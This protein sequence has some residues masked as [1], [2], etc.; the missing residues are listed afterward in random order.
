MLFI[1]NKVE[2]PVSLTIVKQEEKDRTALQLAT[3]NMKFDLFWAVD[4]G[5]IEAFSKRF[6]V[7]TTNVKN[8]VNRHDFYVTDRLTVVGR[9]KTEEEMKPSLENGICLTTVPI[10]LNQRTDE[11]KSMPRHVIVVVS[12]DDDSVQACMNDDRNVLESASFVVDGYRFQI[13]TIKWSSWKALKHKAAL[14][15]TDKDG[16]EQGLELGVTPTG[17]GN[18]IQDDLIVLTDEELKKF[19]EE[20]EELKKEEA[21]A[22]ARKKEAANN[23]PKFDRNFNNQSRSQGQRSQN[24]GSGKPYAKKGKTNQG[25]GGYNGG[26][27][28]FKDFF[29]SR[30]DRSGNRGRK[31]FG[32]GNRKHR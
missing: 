26:N 25:A 13:F 32:K 4:E 21:E 10:D 19:K 27:R 3:G 5:L 14:Y 7:G 31:N 24:N 17:K 29:D 9:P 28:P 1:I 20:Q 16:E 2:E 6:K 18:R 12:K 23:R 8:L 22:A 11:E 15:I 30:D